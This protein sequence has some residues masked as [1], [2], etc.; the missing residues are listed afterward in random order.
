MDLYPVMKCVADI[1]T[2]FLP[3]LRPCWGLNVGM[4]GD[5]NGGNT[6][7]YRVSHILAIQFIQDENQK[8]IFQ[9]HSNSSIHT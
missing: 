7:H 9:L 4:F 3:V 2:T 6:G 8:V 1:P 5:W